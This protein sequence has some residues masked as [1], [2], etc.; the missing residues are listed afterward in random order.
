MMA[1]ALRRLGWTALVLWGVLTLTFLVSFA[2][3]GDPARVVAG[4]QARPADVA[5][6]RT[7]LGLDR[8]L[9]TQYGMFFRRLLHTG[10]S[11]ITKKDKEHASCSAFGPVH[12]DLGMSYQQRKPVAKLLSEKLP[13]TMLLAV[14][15]M[16]IQVSIGVL[17]GTLA[18]M[19]RNTPIDGGVV[20]LSLVGISAPTFLTGIGLQWLFAHRLG[21]L[22]FDGYGQTLGERLVHSLLPGMTLGFF[23]AAYY[24]RLVRDEVLLQAQ[25][26]YV[27]TARAKG[28][29]PARVLFS[30]VL[31]NTLMPLLTVIGLD[32]GTLVGGAIVTEKLFRW[33]GIGRLSVDAVIE[34]DGP[35]VMGTVLI[36]STAIVIA[37]LLVDLSYGL[38]DPRTRRG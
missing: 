11:E 7:Q 31:R 1:R 25:Q 33:P 2:L 27:R 29:S 10:P 26:D 15:A 18:A 14:V 21:W 6:I 16:L 34:R 17:T 23:G 19:R 35:V 22:P 24:T 13:A 20:A 8:P 28:A 4:P 36:A 5:R 37:N 30:H 9:L 12:V 3:P 32:F 38:L